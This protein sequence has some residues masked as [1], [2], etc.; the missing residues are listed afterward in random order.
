VQLFT[1]TGETL[2]DYNH[3]QTSLGVGVSLFRF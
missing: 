1:A 3:S 2:L